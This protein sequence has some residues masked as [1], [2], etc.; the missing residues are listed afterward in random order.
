MK[1]SSFSPATS[2]AAESKCMGLSTC[3]PMWGE[4]RRIDTLAKSPSETRADQSIVKGASPG[5][6]GLET[7]TAGEISQMRFM[8]NSRKNGESGKARANDVL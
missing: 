6:T 3:A 2:G 8:V 7:P 5:K 4:N 1:V